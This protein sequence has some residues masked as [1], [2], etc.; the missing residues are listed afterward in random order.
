MTRYTP[1]T[2]AAFLARY[3]DA[4]E[5]ARASMLAEHGISAEELASWIKAHTLG[6][7]RGLRVTLKEPGTVGYER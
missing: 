4:D 7:V 1:Q 5:Q 3:N 2:K 6:G